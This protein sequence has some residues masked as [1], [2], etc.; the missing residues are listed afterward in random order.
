MFCA[1]HALDIGDNR[2]TQHRSQTYSAHKIDA[3]RIGATCAEVLTPINAAIIR[4]TRSMVEASTA[5]GTIVLEGVH[6]SW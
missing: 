1:Q 4:K 5:K 2:T 3:G 6:S